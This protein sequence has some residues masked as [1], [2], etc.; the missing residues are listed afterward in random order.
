MSVTNHVHVSNGC[1]GCG[2]CVDVCPT[3]VLRMVDGRA[4]PVYEG[5]CQGCFLCTID[6]PYNAISVMVQ[7]GG[8]ER[9][10]LER[11]NKDRLLKVS[12]SH[13][14]GAD[15]DFQSRWVS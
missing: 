10:L 13:S 15:G 1:T 8:E 3:D 14:E 12:E 7:L 4:V 6:C 5:D 9:Q 2:V 11:V